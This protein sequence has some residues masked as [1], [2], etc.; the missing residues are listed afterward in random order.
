MEGV[1]VKV[2]I[3]VTSKGKQE[4]STTVVGA[5]EVTKQGDYT[6]SQVI[7]HLQ[8]LTA[9]ALSAVQDRV[10]VNVKEEA[11]VGAPPSEDWLK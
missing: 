9:G 8:K 2:K 4:Y 3:E 6:K 7:E 1:T 11:E 10:V 5:M